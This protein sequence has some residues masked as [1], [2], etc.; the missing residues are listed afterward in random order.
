MGVVQLYYYLAPRTEVS[1]VAK[2]LIR[3][4]KSHREIQSVILSTIATLTTR[5]KLEI[6]TNL[7]TEG[8]FPS[9]CENSSHMFQVQTWSLLQQPYKP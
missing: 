1:T 8:K 9:F 4:T 7:A 5:Y 2:A 6:L 3:L